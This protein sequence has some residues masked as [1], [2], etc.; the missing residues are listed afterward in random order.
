MAQY[1]L[2]IVLIE[3]TCRLGVMRPFVEDPDLVYKSGVAGAFGVQ[4]LLRLA[5][6]LSF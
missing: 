1:A 4:V 5:S 2:H 3:K 6:A